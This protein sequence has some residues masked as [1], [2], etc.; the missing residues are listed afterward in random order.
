[1]FLVH[2]LGVLP[3]ESLSSILVA[4]LVGLLHAV[5]LMFGN[6]MLFTSWLFS[7]LLAALLTSLLLHA[8]MARLPALPRALAQ[9]ATFTALA[10]GA[11][12]GLARAFL[13]QD[14]AHVFELLRFMLLPNLF[15]LIHLFNLLLS[16]PS[17]PSSSSPPPQVE[18]HG[19][20]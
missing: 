18:V 17:S 1:M 3:K 5:A 14:D 2:V 16:S 20:P 4:Q 7:C 15:L 6:E 19:V 10:L 9:L 12:M 11:K 13:V 8:P